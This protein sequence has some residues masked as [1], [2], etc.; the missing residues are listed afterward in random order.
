MLGFGVWAWGG[1]WGAGKWGWGCGIA[2]M[3]WAWG[4]PWADEDKETAEGECVL[5]ES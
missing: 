2:G 5:T 1:R 3:Q 4:R